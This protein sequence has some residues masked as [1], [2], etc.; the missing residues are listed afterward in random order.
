MSG[1]QGTV[2]DGPFT[3]AKGLVAC[4]ALFQVKSIDEAIHWKTSFLQVLGKGECEI[5]PMFE[6]ADFP[7]E[8]FTAAEAAREEKTRTQMKKNT[9][10][11]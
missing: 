4:D 7:P 2:N 11:K 6:A 1:G 3:E 8:V 5:R 10:K 9:K